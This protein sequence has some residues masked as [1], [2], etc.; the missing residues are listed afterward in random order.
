MRANAPQRKLSLGGKQ[1][2]FIRFDTGLIHV[3]L[4]LVF[5]D[6]NEALVEVVA[7]PGAHR[8][9]SQSQHP[10]DA[11]MFG[12]IIHHESYGDPSIHYDAFHFT[13]HPLP[14]TK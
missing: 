3:Q 6:I 7:S 1:N 14:P 9:R 8:L 4:G 10:N 12:G 13:T 5:G 2:C 11:R